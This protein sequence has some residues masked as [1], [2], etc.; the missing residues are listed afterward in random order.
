ML[1]DIL[2]EYDIKSHVPSDVGV[3]QKFVQ[4]QKLNTQQ[5]LNKIALWSNQNL[6]R[7]NESKTKYL[8][9]TR[10]KTEFATRIV[11]NESVLERVKTIKLL[12]I[13]L[14]EDGGRQ[15]NTSEMC[16][17]AYARV[18]MITK[19]KYAGVSKENLLLLYKL[20]VRSCLEYCVVA[21]HSSISSRQ[22]AAI[23]RCQAV[24]LKIILQESYVS[25]E[26]ALEMT[27]LE[28]LANRRTSRCLKFS[29]DCLKHKTNK[30]FFPENAETNKSIR[31]KEKFKVNFAYTNIYKNSAIP[32]CQRLLN[33]QEMNQREGEERKGGDGRREGGGG[34]GGG[35]GGG[36]G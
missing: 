31:N 10:S 21:W 19:L 34:G 23:E 16:K 20:H 12:G 32:Y 8:I 18:G 4:P 13:W 29:Q 35:D 14:Q 15:T 5:N 2:T 11:V 9:F 22:E 27:G 26:A 3:G 30:R 24:C 25:Y 17:R 36:G 1:G 6:M 7:L 28:T 33:Q